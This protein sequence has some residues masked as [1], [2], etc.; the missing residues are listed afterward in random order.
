MKVKV[1]MTPEEMI[2]AVKCY[3]EL[4]AYRK[5]GYTPEQVQELHDKHWMECMQIAHY[6][7]DL[8]SNR[9]WIPVSER[10]PEDGQEALVITQKGKSVR[11]VRYNK[12]YNM[13]DII[14]GLGTLGTYSVTHWMPLPE[15]PAEKEV[16][17]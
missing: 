2:V 13:F 15:P 10:L 12:T 5:T 6:D 11:F 14:G 9:G 16:Q 3:E 1:E 8:N 4:K 17:T 7:N